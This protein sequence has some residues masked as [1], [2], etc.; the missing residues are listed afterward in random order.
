MEALED[1]AEPSQSETSELAVAEGLEPGPQQLHAAAARRVDPAHELEQGGLPAAGRS[2]DGHVLA[3]LHREGDAAKRVHRLPV[4]G[5]V[6]A[7]VAGDQERRA[8]VASARSVA[9]IGACDASQAG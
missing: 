1:E 4:H 5:I 9:A 6:L 3:R 7:Q 8:H 2:G